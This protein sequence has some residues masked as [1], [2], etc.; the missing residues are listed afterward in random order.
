MFFQDSN[1]VAVDCIKLGWYLIYIVKTKW[2]IIEQRIY[3]MSTS[4][5]RLDKEGAQ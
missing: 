4:L 5:Y 3:M 2:L 1:S